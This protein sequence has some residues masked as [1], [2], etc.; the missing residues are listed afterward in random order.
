MF[1]GCT[2]PI[3]RKMFNVAPQLRRSKMKLV[4]GKVEG[5]AFL[6]PY[7]EGLGREDTKGGVRSLS[8]SPILHLQD[9]RHRVSP[10]FT[11]LD[12]HQHHHQDNHNHNRPLD[13]D[14]NSFK[15]EFIP[16]FVLSPVT[17]KNFPNRRV[18]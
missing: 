8:S 7:M 4:Q 14:Q 3:R 2:A 1:E 13:I 9:N 15:T 16:P 12:L 11:I 5:D 17:L 10:Q 6:E 18:N